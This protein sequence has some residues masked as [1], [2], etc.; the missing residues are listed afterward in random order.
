M[1]I[2]HKRYS[3]TLRNLAPILAEHKDGREILRAL[4]SYERA[5]GTDSEW[6]VAEAIYWIGCN[7]H[8]G[9]GCPLYA[10]MCATQFEPGMLARGPEVCARYLYEEIAMIL[11]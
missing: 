3:E 11:S 1:R 8:G 4:V 6:D 9:Q 10:A 2:P 5:N 7:Y